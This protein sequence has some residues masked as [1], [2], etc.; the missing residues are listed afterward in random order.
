MI[1]LDE[2]LTGEITK[3]LQC[4]VPNNKEVINIDED[5]EQERSNIDDDCD[6]FAEI[7]GN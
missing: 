1:K 5:I 2:H 4:V 3:N 7:D 6:Y